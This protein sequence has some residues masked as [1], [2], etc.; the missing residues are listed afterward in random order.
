VQKSHES[1]INLVHMTSF[2]NSKSYNA[3]QLI[4]VGK[5]GLIYIFIH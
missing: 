1:F 5:K 2:L 4:C 3:I